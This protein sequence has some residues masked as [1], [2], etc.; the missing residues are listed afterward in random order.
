MTGLPFHGEMPVVFHG[1]RISLY[2][3]Y[4]GCNGHKPFYKPWTGK[5]TGK[6]GTRRIVECIKSV[7]L[8]MIIL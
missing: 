6:S 4:R 5:K 2:I 7:L 3:L 8:Q 1:L